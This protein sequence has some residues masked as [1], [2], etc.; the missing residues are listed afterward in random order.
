MCNGYLNAEDG[1][2][3][4]GGGLWKDS[5]DLVCDNYDGSLAF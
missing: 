2:P 4:T 5:L 3:S 1:M